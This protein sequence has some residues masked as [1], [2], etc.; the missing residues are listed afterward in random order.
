MLLCSC[1]HQQAHSSNPAGD[2]RA[3]L[4]D[5]L[6]GPP[7]ENNVR[8]HFVE[9]AATSRSVGKLSGIARGLSHLEEHRTNSRHRTLK[10][11]TISFDRGG[12]I[13]CVIRNVSD[14][15]ACLEIENPIGI[16]N[17]FTLVMKTDHVM[18]TCHVAWRSGRRIGVRFAPEQKN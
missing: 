15:G 18:R 11:G 3:K 5:F 9:G 10:A 12:G 7:V 4:Y 17:D 6:T 13:D 1:R 16:P 8:W 2:N 14:T